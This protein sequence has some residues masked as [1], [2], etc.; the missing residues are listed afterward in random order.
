MDC[1]PIWGEYDLEQ[2]DEYTTKFKNSFTHCWLP[3]DH[4]DDLNGKLVWLKNLGDGLFDREEVVGSIN[5]TPVDNGKGGY[6]RHNPRRYRYSGL[7]V[8]DIDFDGDMDIVTAINTEIKE[9]SNRVLTKAYDRNRYMIYRNDGDGVFSEEQFT[10]Y[11]RENYAGKMKLEDV[12]GSYDLDLIVGTRRASGVL[13]FRIIGTRALRLLNKNSG[14]SFGS[15]SVRYHGP[16]F[17]WRTTILEVED[18]RWRW[19]IKIM[20]LPLPAVNLLRLVHQE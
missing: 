2:D 11:H 4:D 9:A 16:T 18:F 12:G 1:L 14:A 6:N 10:S 17:G 15:R 8:G 20:L 3:T 7:D 5:I 19:R 13:I